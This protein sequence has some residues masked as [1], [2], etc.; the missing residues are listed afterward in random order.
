M[1]RDPDRTAQAI[2]DAATTEFAAHGIGGARVDAIAARANVN[3][4]M[5]Y[6]YFGDKDALYLAVLEN[7]YRSIR[8][9]ELE[10]HL[11][12]T[13]PEE[14]IRALARFTWQ[15]F[16]DHPEF[17]SLLAT[18]NLHK[19]KYLKNS[20]VMSSIHS[21]FMERLK[22]VLRRGAELGIFKENLDPVD[23]Y[24]AIAS[25]CAFYL[26]NRHTLSTIFRRDLMA[27]DALNHWGDGVAEMV[28]AHVRRSASVV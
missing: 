14:S 22:L 6:H 10:L 9:A 26:S 27:E 24:I 23:I 1:P 17:L 7:A 11:D 3:K 21:S 19:A 15:Y 18:E 28:L 20:S 16:L 4:R 8:N 12:K 5:L 13:P 25:L 2:L